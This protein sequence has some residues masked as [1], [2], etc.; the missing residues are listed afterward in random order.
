MR[1]GDPLKPRPPRR[2]KAGSKLMSSPGTNLALAGTLLPM[3]AIFPEI[4]GMPRLL[5]ATPTELDGE[6]LPFACKT[7]AIAGS[8]TQVRA[9]ARANARVH[10]Q[11]SAPNSDSRTDAP[12]LM[13]IS[14]LL[15]GHFL[16][17]IKLSHET[18]DLP[19]NL[20]QML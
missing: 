6:A 7:V 10:L 13:R 1:F 17:V 16:E 4:S 9:H 18:T 15:R 8:R 19:A 20:S 3:D 12:E 2:S 5:R 14:Q 11:A